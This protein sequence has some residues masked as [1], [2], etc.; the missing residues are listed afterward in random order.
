MPKLLKQV[1]H[2]FLGGAMQRLALHNNEGE[3]G[4]GGKTEGDK[5]E[6]EKPAR[7]EGTGETPP[8]PKYELKLPENSVLDAA[9]TERLT[10]FAKERQLSPEHTQQALEFMHSELSSNLESVLKAHQPGG[11]AWVE[12]DRLWREAAVKDPAIGA[13][14]ENTFKAA[15]EKAKKAAATFFPKSVLDFLETSGM[16]SNP[17]LLKGLLAIDSAMAEGKFTAGSHVEEEQPKSR[18]DRFYSKSG[19]A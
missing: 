11:E 15:V 19:A 17:D 2:R 14:D 12:Q 8:E 16:G 10:S 6:G 18:A 9:V 3:G 7:K 13:G 4:A 1:N 5:P